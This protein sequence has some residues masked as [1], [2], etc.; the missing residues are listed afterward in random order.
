MNA[1]RSPVLAQSARRSSRRSPGFTLVELLAVL[2]IVGVLAGILIPL[3]SMSRN[4]AR[5]SVCA[6][7][8]REMGHA[9]LLY[10][11]D[12]K[13]NLPKAVGNSTLWPNTYWMWQLYPYLGLRDT[14]NPAGQKALIYDGVFRCPS[15]DDFDLSSSSWLKWGSYGMNT[16]NPASAG[17][18]LQVNINDSTYIPLPAHVALVVEC[19]DAKVQNASYAY[20]MPLLRHSSKDNILFCDGHVESV[21]KNGLQ[22]P[23]SAPYSG[24]N[25]LVLP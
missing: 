14:A 4:S 10:A 9:F 5:A 2:A 19:V 6:G 17:T 16:F 21:P 13:N 1:S 25:G 7:N 8:L 18:A 24:K 3:V 20:S 12:H 15:N 22:W 11:G 23:G